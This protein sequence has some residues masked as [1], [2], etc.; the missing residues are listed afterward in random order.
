MKL[1]KKSF[2][3]AATLV[4][5]TISI[6]SYAA[7]RDFVIV[8]YYSDSSYTEV[9]GEAMF[10][11]RNNVIQEGIVTPYAREIERTPCSNK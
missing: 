5:S 7:W 1:L 4:I 3:V 9:V 11:C 6:V 8:W 2:L 10:T